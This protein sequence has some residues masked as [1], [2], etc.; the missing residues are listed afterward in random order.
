MK[1]IRIL[2]FASVAVLAF[3]NS[4]KKDDNPDTSKYTIYTTGQYYGVGGTFSCYW[5]NSER[6]DVPDLTP[7]YFDRREIFVSNGDVYLAGARNISGTQSVTL[8]P[9]YWKN[10]VRTDLN[11]G[12]YTSGSAEYIKV[13]NG[14][15]YT[16]GK[17][18]KNTG[19]WYE[20][21]TK[22]CYWINNE[23]TD[24]TDF[25][26][27]FKDTYVS[28]L[29]VH[30]NDVYVSG[31][32]AV[33]VD[34]VYSSSNLY[35]ACYWK[36]GVRTDIPNSSPNTVSSTSI[37][38]DNG[39]VYV[40]GWT[41]YFLEDIREAWYSVDGQM[42]IVE[43]GEWGSISNIF[44]ENG[45]VYLAG[46]DASNNACF[47]KGTSKTS[48]GQRVVIRGM[49]VRDGIVFTAGWRYEPGIDASYYPCYWVNTKRVELLFP[50]KDNNY[51]WNNWALGI[52]VE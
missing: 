42:K 25:P 46:S 44:V 10:G 31:G 13:A 43:T 21:E 1:N 12:D 34:N 32:Y 6:V 40:A 8:A 47:W 18:S 7:D 49:Y 16:A 38:V 5:K 45:A 35:H 30:G 4:C 22:L 23:R 24:I 41:R 17:V 51:K 52:F 27:K 36:N 9:S 48:I 33:N 2:M 15:V 50:V 20:N 37:F 26:A 3:A 28:G 19:A 29:F 14:K 39:K 11:M